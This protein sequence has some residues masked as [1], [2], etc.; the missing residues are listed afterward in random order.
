M[1]SP[2]LPMSWVS[3]LLCVFWMAAPG[4]LRAAEPTGLEASLPGT[5]WK[6]PKT[7]EP[8]KVDGKAAAKASVWQ[9]VRFLS[10]GKFSAWNKAKIVYD[11]RWQVVGP[12]SVRLTCNGPLALIL[13]F[14][15]KGTKFSVGTEPVGGGNLLGH[16][17]A[18]SPLVGKWRWRGGD[19]VTLRED[20]QALS[21]DGN[22]IWRSLGGNRYELNWRHGVFVDTA[23]LVG[24][25]NQLIVKNQHGERF[26]AYRIVTP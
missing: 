1:I 20:G 7:D 18:L 12:Q 21:V 16:A 17:P 23:E 6:W 26:E 25:N 5:V 24:D 4:A 11:G 10:D 22:G 8:V 3:A 9:E 15:D 2:R 14:D 13:F 19:I